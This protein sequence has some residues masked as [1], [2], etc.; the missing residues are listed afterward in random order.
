VSRAAYEPQGAPPYRD[1]PP[2]GQFYGVDQD[3]YGPRQEYA[4][5]QDYGQ[6]YNYPPQR[7]SYPVAM[8]EIDDDPYS[9][10]P[11]LLTRLGP[12]GLAA[13]VAA[14]LVT[15]GAAA[16]VVSVFGSESPVVQPATDGPTPVEAPS[17]PVV[18]ADSTS[19]APSPSRSTRSSA[20]AA[21]RVTGDPRQEA[22][23]VGLVNQERLRAGCRRPLQTDGRLRNAARAHST[24][25]ASRGFFSHTGSDGS[26]P[27]QRMRRAGYGQPLAEN[28]A[29][30]QRSARD[31][32]RAWM[33]S[34]EHRR[35]ILN[36]DARGIGV[37]LAVRNGNEGFWTQD[38][39][40]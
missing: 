31:V 6:P 10:R 4:P 27:E 22:A 3:D 8:E 1:D 14:L 40:R 30:G 32:V 37:G 23:V 25:M 11:T 36:C 33:A 16:A 17:D 21:G 19:A 29:R 28:L 38:F 35:N 5:R 2:P 24:D 39:G 26:S 15:F 20:S 12:V 34:P 9:R 18:P 13:I 7:P